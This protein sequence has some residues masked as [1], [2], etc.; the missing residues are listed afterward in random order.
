MNVSKERL[1]E[2]YENVARLAGGAQ[3]AEKFVKPGISG[4]RIDLPIGEI[5]V[6]DALIGLGVVKDDEEARVLLHSILQSSLAVIAMGV[7]KPL[8][9]TF[10]LVKFG[11]FLGIQAGRVKVEKGAV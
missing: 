3:E 2:L 1:I 5:N 9:A 4:R 6:P 11:F 10:D 7:D 8:E